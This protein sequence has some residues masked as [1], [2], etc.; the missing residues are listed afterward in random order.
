MN[1]DAV[2]TIAFCEKH[3]FDYPSFMVKPIVLREAGI[4]DRITTGIQNRILKAAAPKP[5]AGTAAPPAGSAATVAPAAPAPTSPAPMTPDAR[6]AILANSP[7]IMVTDG[8]TTERQYFAYPDLDLHQPGHKEILDSIVASLTGGDKTASIVAMNSGTRQAAIAAGD[9]V[10]TIKPISDRASIDQKAKLDKALMDLSVL[11]L[12]QRKLL[13]GSKAIVT[14]AQLA[15]LRTEIDKRL[16]D[17]PA[18]DPAAIAAKE[19]AASLAAA[20]S[21]GGLSP[22][23]AKLMGSGAPRPAGPPLPPPAA[24]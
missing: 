10:T 5:A 21:A 12:N 18:E 9:K 16:T 20:A 22:A 19:E 11:I 24:P 8:R 1:F 6:N 14:N 4:W 23:A 2:T 3:M 15:Q 7:M 17:L 13:T